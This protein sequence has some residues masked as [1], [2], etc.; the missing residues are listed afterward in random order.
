MDILTIGNKQH[1]ARWPIAAQM[2]V[3]SSVLVGT[4]GGGAQSRS[5]T[6]RTSVAQQTAEL[7]VPVQASNVWRSLRVLKPGAGAAR[8]VVAP[9]RAMTMAEK[10]MLIWLFVE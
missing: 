4:V 9:A 8:T 3:K 10:C 6:P 1:R 2:S 5:A 7:S